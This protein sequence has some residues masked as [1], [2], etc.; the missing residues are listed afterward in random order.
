MKNGLRAQHSPPHSDC[1]ECCLSLD[2]PLIPAG[3]HEF[4]WGVE[5]R[6]LSNEFFGSLHM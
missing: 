6:T 4:L 2:E 3:P 1:T 5:E